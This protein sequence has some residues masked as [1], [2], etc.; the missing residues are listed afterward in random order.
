MQGCAI[1]PYTDEEGNVQYNPTLVVPDGIKRIGDYAFGI[2]PYTSNN[3]SYPASMRAEHHRPATFVVAAL[4][5]M[6]SPLAKV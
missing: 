1:Q 4:A 6:H 2:F 5:T 3:V